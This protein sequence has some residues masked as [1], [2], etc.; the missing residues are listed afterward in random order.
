MIKVKPEHNMLQRDIITYLND[1]GGDDPVALGH[2]ILKEQTDSMCLPCITT[3]DDAKVFIKKYQSEV[4]AVVNECQEIDGSWSCLYWDQ[5]RHPIA[6]TF[7]GFNFY[8]ATLAYEQI[9]FRILDDIE[10]EEC[11]DN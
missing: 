7:N 2:Q 3:Y 11:D 8:I 9:L 4:E 10:N 1:F 5:S 6:F